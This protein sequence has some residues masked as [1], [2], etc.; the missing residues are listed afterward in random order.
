MDITECK[1]GGREGKRGGS[2]RKDWEGEDQERRTGERQ[3][4]WGGNGGKDMGG[5][6]VS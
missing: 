3:G 6:C 5:R 4:R 1:E 2:K